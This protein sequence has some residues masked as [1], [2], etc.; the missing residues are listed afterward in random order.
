MLRMKRGEWSG[1]SLDALSDALETLSDG[2]QPVLSEG[3]RAQ[4]DLLGVDPNVLRGAGQSRLLGEPVTFA[5]ILAVDHGVIA[6]EVSPI[7]RRE[8]FATSRPPASPPA[9][10]VVMV[11]GIGEAGIEERLESVA[12]AI[13]TALDC[14][15]EPFRYTSDR[16]RALKDEG[17]ESP[18]PPS[19]EEQAGA[20]VLADSVARQAMLAIASAGGLLRSDLPKQ[21]GADD[22]SRAADVIAALGDA[23]VIDSDL[24]IIC[25]RDSTQVARVPNRAA[26]DAAAKAGVRCA[27]GRPILEE[28]VEDALAL[29]ALGR[30]LLDGS[31]WMSL[32]LL[33][34]LHRLGIDYEQMLIEVK[35]G[36]DEMDCFVDISG[37]LTLFEL[38]DK[39]FS[40][41]NA[42]SFG[43]KIGIHRPE[44]SVVVTTSYVGNDAKEHF[45]RSRD[46]G[47]EYDIRGRRST[48]TAVRYIE[49]L[50]NLARGLADL[51]DEVY[52][53]DAAMALTK[54]MAYGMPDG[55]SLVGALRVRHQHGDQDPGNES[56]DVTEVTAGPAIG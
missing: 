24:V 3:L 30:R 32:I 15:C 34:R 37:E 53:R 1:E 25:R 22:R 50:D 27:C 35:S 40:L 54:P 14:K 17:M 11:Y 41:G 10:S 19:A 45:K 43:A 49:G 48:P 6:V 31:R 20:E 33:D 7:A 21:L 46:A 39:E 56:D 36:G 51:I 29:S 23:G 9:T 5:E 44:H 18:G 38:K 12:T 28:Q 42:Y 2:Y 16:F 55:S 4:A 52:A 8:S 47:Q 13:E 26:I